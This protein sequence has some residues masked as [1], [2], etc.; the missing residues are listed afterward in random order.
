[1]EILRE[2]TEAMDIPLW[3]WAVILVA[4][5]AYVVVDWRWR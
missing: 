4:M 3:A 2:R 1:M 5:V